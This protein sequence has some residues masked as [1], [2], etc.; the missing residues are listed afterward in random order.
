M[1]ANRTAGRPEP[2][3]YMAAAAST[4]GGRT[5]KQRALRR[6]AL[7]SGSVVLDAGCGPGT[8]LLNLAEAVGPAGKVIGLD[9]DEV[10]LA[11]ARQ[12]AAGAAT[13]EI[14]SGDVHALPLPDDSVDRARTDRV[15]QHVRDPELALAEL[16]RVTKPGGRAVIAEP[17]WGTLVVDSPL[18]A[19]SAAFT[20]FTCRHVV[21]NATLGRRV[22][23]LATAVGW[24]RSTVD[25]CAL[26]LTDF[27]EADS[28]LGLG[29]NSASAVRAGDMTAG[30]R[31]SWLASLVGQPVLAAVTL[32]VTTL[33]KSA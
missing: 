14:R 9:N 11:A 27:E 17:D 33:T 28:I 24:T 20:S 7:G 29:R 32:V 3:S 6:L 26:T 19:V 16:L 5:Y 30:E 2:V 8:D 22:G 31:E 15:L 25:G 23:R 12:R 13:V 21:R 4:A 18:E 1:D 10:M